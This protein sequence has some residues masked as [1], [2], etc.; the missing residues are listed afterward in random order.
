MPIGK[1]KTTIRSRGPG[2]REGEAPM[3]ARCDL[4]VHS[5]HSNRPSEWILRRLGSPESFMEPAEVY[6][7]C[8]R[9][10]M[11]FVTISDHDVFS[12][13]AVNARLGTPWYSM[14]KNSERLANSADRR[15]SMFVA[16]RKKFS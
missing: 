8:K 12:I 6:R 14:S 11:R 9:R 16:S 15:L 7:R 5:K 2:G 10:G 4:H 13:G 1:G 3:T